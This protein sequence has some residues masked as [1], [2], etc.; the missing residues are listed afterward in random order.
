[1]E[2]KFKRRNARTREL[3]IKI[4]FVLLFLIAAAG[5]IGGGI[6]KVQMEKQAAE[7]EAQARREEEERLRKERQER[8]IAE[9]KK[10]KE[11]WE[12]A[13]AE[14]KAREAEEA[15][16]QRLEALERA[17]IEEENR[18]TDMEQF[19]ITAADMVKGFH[20]KWSVYIE[21]MKYGNKVVVNNRQIY[22]A[23]LIKMF[24]M[25]ATYGNMEQVI[26]NTAAYTGSEESAKNQIDR[27]LKNMIEVS[28]NESYNELV[29]LHSPKKSFAEGCG[30][31]NKYL[32]E[33]GYGQTG[34]HT[35]L[36][37][38]HSKYKKDGLGR[39]VTSV[40]DC[41]KLLENIYNGTCVSKEASDS[42]I[43]LLLNQS[44]DLKIPSGLPEGIKVANKTGETS[45]V[46]HDAA[47]V[48]GEKEDFIL[49]IMTEN[50][51]NT[52]KV[53]GDI[54]KFTDTVYSMLNDKSDN[55][56]AGN[57]DE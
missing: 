33:N 20:G 41:G 3:E 26:K 11:E 18:K 15:E 2:K 23:S 12:K 35:T 56:S 49:C 8:L 57:S 45:D 29:K 13:E 44:N 6:Y 38:A 48:Y 9:Q 52:G 19:Q 42:M 36:H 4:T 10:K 28:D 16:R 34:V 37:P 21:D 55:E 47:I 40:E 17:K 43:Q 1:M 53:Y 32:N 50:V 39:N 27:L 25:A 14:R 51:A 5:L 24:V 7:Q 46:Q 54:H 22:S 30:V 31:I